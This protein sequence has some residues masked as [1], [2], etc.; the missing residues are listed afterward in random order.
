RGERATLDGLLEALQR[1]DITLTQLR[2]TLR[3]GGNNFLENV[4]AALMSGST[5]TNRAAAL[6]F[7]NEAVEM[8]KL[9]AHEQRQRAPALEARARKLPPVARMLCPALLKV[10]EAGQRN[11][12]LLRCGVAALAA[13]RFR[14]DKGRWPTAVAELVPQ[15]L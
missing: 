11:Q 1:G 12:A 15:Y 9:P 6:E 7:M 8:A 3:V 5:R 10:A 2:T 14:R 4:G 13:E